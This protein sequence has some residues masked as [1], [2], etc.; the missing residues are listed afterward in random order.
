MFGGGEADF[1]GNLVCLVYL[2]SRIEE[3]NKQDIDPKVNVGG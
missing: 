2:V 3:T 1:S